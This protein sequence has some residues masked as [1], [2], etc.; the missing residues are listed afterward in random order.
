MYIKKI[1][2]IPTAKVNMGVKAWKQVL[3]GEPMAPN[4][5]MR[6]FILEPGGSIPSHT[7]T[8]EHEQFVLNGRA[9]I[10]IGEKTYDVA[11]DD[12]IYIPAGTAHWYEAAGETPFEFIC[13]VPNRED[14]VEVLE[15]EGA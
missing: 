6:R 12:C 13:V 1:D 11:K 4:F 15:E 9:R 2:D 8:V 10:G 14:V 3:I 7:N 5:A